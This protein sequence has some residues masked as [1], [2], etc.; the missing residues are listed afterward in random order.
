[1]SAA[2]ATRVR[3]AVP[4]VGGLFLTLLGI[5]AARQRITAAERTF[6]EQSMPVEIVVAAV[7]LPAQTPFDEKN[8]AKTSLPAAAVGK[9]HVRTKD[10]PLLLGARPRWDIDQG[11][12]V[13]WTDVEEPF[14]EATF[15]RTIPKGRRA[16]TLDAD[17]TASF[18]GLVRPGD[19]VDLHISGQAGGTSLL[20]NI[21]V[22]AVGGNFR[23]GHDGGESADA[24][25]L[26]LSVTPEEGR[27]L[28]S[29]GDAV[30]WFLRNPEEAAAAPGRAPVR[31]RAMP[32]EVWEGGVLVKDGCG[33]PGRSSE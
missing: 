1:M 18:S 7:P 2:W 3:K 4:L 30:R 11:E 33:S 9:R 12:P 15:S 29:A 17:Q 10:F 28:A 27:R 26:T 19:K 31:A 24:S 13:L 16:L 21:P 22:V 23:P 8:L 6:R 32:V 20:D 25:T 5:L 14:D